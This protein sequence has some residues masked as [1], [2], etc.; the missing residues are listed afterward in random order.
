M[1]AVIP[2]YEPNQMLIQL[3]QQLK[4]LKFSVLLIDDGSSIEKQSTFDRLQKM[5]VVL[6]HSKNYGKGRALKTAFS[7]MREQMP[8]EDGIVTV[9]ADG[10][11]SIADI[12]KMRKQFHQNPNRLLLGVRKFS[13]KIP[14]KSKWGN[15][16]TKVVFALSSGKLLSDTQTG[17]RGFH[18]F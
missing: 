13:G 9:D 7:Y 16:I 3:V 15:A 2:A 1:V 17:L 12:C 18:S 5:A 14:W 11:H 4:K 8:G 6:H 10:Q